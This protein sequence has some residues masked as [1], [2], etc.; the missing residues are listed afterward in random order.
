[1]AT[2]SAEIERDVAAEKKTPTP[3]TCSYFKLYSQADRLDGLLIG[4]VRAKSV[5]RS[6]AMR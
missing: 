2:E 5:H 4:L 3:E 6:F 1:M